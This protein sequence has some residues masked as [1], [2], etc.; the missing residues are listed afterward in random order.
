[1]FNLTAH[2]E[3]QRLDD[4]VFALQALGENKLPATANAV[5]RAT[6]AV[7]QRWIDNAKGAFHRT[8]GDYL[9]GIYDGLQY[10]YERDI[11]KGA[12]FNTVPHADWVE[13]GTPAHDMKKALFTS[14]QVRISAKGKRYLIIPFRHGTP[15]RGSHEGGVGQQRA[16]LRTMP[17]AIYA[18][19]KNLNR[20]RMIS[21]RQVNNPVNGGTAIRYSY[22][23]GGK[24]SGKALEDAGLTDVGRRPHWKSSPYAGMVRFP[25]DK[26][27]GQSTYVTFRVMHEDSTGWIHPGTPPMKLAEKTA[28]EMEPVVKQIIEMGFDQDIR[29]FFGQS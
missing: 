10:P 22:Q 13:N 24:L 6:G 18:M 7:Q 27:T 8:S 29:G 23:W 11:Y 19:A 16:T 26:N 3:H 12:V 15:S 5:E 21:A 1:M 20:S 14:S 28:R 2:V 25:R 4:V 9:Q 17:Q